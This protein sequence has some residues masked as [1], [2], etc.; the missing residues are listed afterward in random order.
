MM[1]RK[2]VFVRCTNLLQNG[3]RNRN[4][5]AMK[6]VTRANSLSKLEEVEG[7]LRGLIVL[8]KNVIVLAIYKRQCGPMPMV[9]SN[10][11]KLKFNI[12]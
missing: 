1:P 4:W 2:S 7:A 10:N 12:N 5:L 9:L 11:I 3:W 8:L 6:E